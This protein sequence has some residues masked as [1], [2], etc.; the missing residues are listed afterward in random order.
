MV[1]L[2]P[3]QVQVTQLI[4]AGWSQYKAATFLG[5]SRSTVKSILYAAK[6]KGWSKSTGDAI[7]PDKMHMHGQSVLYGPDGTP[8]LAWHKYNPER[9]FSADFVE[10][11]VS[12]V[13]DQGSLPKKRPPSKYAHDS[14]CAEV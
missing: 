9:A 10:G 4:E 12:R 14:I 8:K 3:R 2:T 5:I 7:T 11:L 6:D 1:G 13:K